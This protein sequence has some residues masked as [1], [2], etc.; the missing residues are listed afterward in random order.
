MRSVSLPPLLLLIAAAG[1]ARAGGAPHNVAVLASAD[2]P[3]SVALATYYGQARAI[4]PENLCLLEGVPDP[5]VDPPGVIDAETFRTQVLEPA[6]A[7]VRASPWAA[8]IDFF[9]T[10][11]GLPYHVRGDG[12]QASLEALLTLGATEVEGEHL[13]RRPPPEAGR[14]LWISPR[15]RARALYGMV[16]ELAAGRFPPPPRHRERL[17]AQLQEVGEE[18]GRMLVPVTWD[19]RP[20]FRIDGESE[21]Q[22][23]ALVDRSLASDDTAPRGLWLCMDGADD[24]RGVRDDECAEA[25]GLLE[26][27]GLDTV[28]HAWDAG[29]TLDVPV[30]AYL[31]GAADLRGAIDGVP[32]RPGAI[33]DNITSF[34]AVP[35]NWRFGQTGE[36]S[37]TSIVRFLRA[38]ATAT[39]GTSAEPLNAPFASA[40]LLVLYATG[41][42]LG[43]VYALTLPF[44]R[45]MNVPVGDPLAAPYARRP[46]VELEAPDPLY[47]DDLVRV[48]ATAAEGWRIVTVA[49]YADGFEVR[50]KRRETLEVR[51]GD[52][53]VDAGARRLRAVA[54]ARPLPRE[55][56]EPFSVGEIEPTPEVP[57]WAALEV[58][59]EDLPRPA[60][61]EGEGEGEAD[62]D[63]DA[64]ADA[65]EEPGVDA[66][67]AAPA[68]DAGTEGDPTD[69]AA[70]DAGGVSASPAAAR[71]RDDGWC[72]VR[73]GVRLPLPLLMLRR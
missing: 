23:R 25:L 1:T 10:L 9:V 58:R 67:T 51:G 35:G 17:P 7:C 72:S 33:A 62:A 15:F 16:S 41:Y 18:S 20:A 32:F 56:E 46:E 38:G 64:G 65:G 59:V 11:R 57:G 2:R 34:G 53:L 50:T 3:D 73:P 42:G 71:P 5:D 22:A 60:E 68:K 29:L 70:P 48:R 21:E 13:W 69:A 39:H 26:A 4:P 54:F 52:L 47:S 40:A 14:P 6:L 27:L 36:E 19:L 49:L 28:F 30:I 24:A 61:G 55:V 63:A 45:W 8:E 12:W 66:D 31:T 44:L 37:Q 43:D